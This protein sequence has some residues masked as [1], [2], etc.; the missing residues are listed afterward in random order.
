MPQGIQD[1]PPPAVEWRRESDDERRQRL[2]R[3]GIV[4][5][6]EPDARANTETSGSSA[7]SA[8]PQNALLNE[9]ERTKKNED[10]ALYVWFGTEAARW[11]PLRSPK[12]TS[13]VSNGSFGLSLELTRTAWR[14]KKFQIGFGP[15]VVIFNGGQFANLEASPIQGQGYAEFSSSE[16]G[17]FVNFVRN[18]QT[19][20]SRW[21]PTF[22]L[23]TSYLPV[24]MITAESQS[25][26]NMIARSDTYS[27][28][29]LSIPGLGLRLAAGIDWGRFLKAEVFYAL[30]GAWP[31]QLRGRVGIQVSMGLSIQDEEVAVR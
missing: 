4:P 7:P 15:T 25:F 2:I 28:N 23:R 8:E 9:I 26:G 24:R 27:R 19:G 10:R 17:G 1:L 18:G 22:S 21:Q 11:T 30:Q 5:S 14:W 31:L 20:E 3:S 29:S 12:N 16:L 6:S 13:T